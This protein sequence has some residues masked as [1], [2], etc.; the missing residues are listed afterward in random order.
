[1]DSLMSCEDCLASN[2]AARKKREEQFREEIKTLEDLLEKEQGAKAIMASD[3][4]DID[5]FFDR[6]LEYSPFWGA[7]W[8]IHTKKF[9]LGRSIDKDIRE[10][11]E[12]RRVLIN[13]QRSKFLL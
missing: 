9:L 10:G 13:F 5:D 3:L 2:F 11:R 4:K 7:T 8:K 12:K 1:M 6:M